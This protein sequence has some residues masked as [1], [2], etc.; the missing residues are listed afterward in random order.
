MT[1][2]RK[3]VGLSARGIGEADTIRPATHRPRSLIAPEEEARHLGP[4]IG[5]SAVP[6]WQRARP[7]SDGMR[8]A[9]EVQRFFHPFF[10]RTGGGPVLTR[11]GTVPVRAGSAARS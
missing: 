2:D 1:E 5:R 3:T 11:V 9:G 8:S 4:P 6:I 10:A 7:N